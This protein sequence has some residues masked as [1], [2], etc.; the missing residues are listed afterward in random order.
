MGIGITLSNFEQAVDLNRFDNSVRFTDQRPNKKELPF[1]TWRHEIDHFGFLDVIFSLMYGS[2]LRVERQN[3][4]LVPQ[5][6]VPS[7][8]QEIFSSLLN[9][10]VG[11]QELIT[12]QRRL[13]GILDNSP[14][15]KNLKLLLAKQSLMY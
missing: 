14:S 11:P 3:G 5:Q 2:S 7:E 4:R 8:W 9:D 10:S 13:E 1:D 6:P 12:Y 15:K